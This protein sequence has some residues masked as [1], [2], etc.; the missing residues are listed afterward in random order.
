MTKIFW[1]FDAFEDGLKTNIFVGETLASLNGKLKA[2][3]HPVFCLG[4]DVAPVLLADTVEVMKKIGDDKMTVLLNKISI[5]GVYRPRVIVAP[6]FS[7]TQIVKHFISHAEKNGA[8]LIA[9][10]SHGRKGVNRAMLGSFAETLLLQSHLPV[11]VVGQNFDQ[12]P[13]WDE[14]LFPT[15]FSDDSSYAF[16]NALR[17]AKTL[18]AKVTLFHHLSP[19]VDPI[20]Q[21]TIAPFGG[22]WV[23][24]RD[25][26]KYLQEKK[27]ESLD[28]WAKI[29]E[30][31][32]IQVKT[33]LDTETTDTSEAILSYANKNNIGLIATGAQSGTLATT[34]FGAIT[35]K[36]V[37]QAQCPVW[38]LRRHS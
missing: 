33:Y 10:G 12:I 37:R 8:D 26:M 14:T 11:L 9:V 30:S 15:D 36:V 20:I 38:V 19:I 5:P 7:Q 29:A 25:G 17:L 35:R 31:Q 16:H 2:E 24:Y 18:N 3:I 28:E 27:Q 23:S 21:S 6:S 22:V 34:L 4:S 13:R 32:G 1:A